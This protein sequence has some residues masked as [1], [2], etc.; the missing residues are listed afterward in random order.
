MTEQTPAQE[1]MAIAR[2]ARAAKLAGAPEGLAT[3]ASVITPVQPV[4]ANDEDLAVRAATQAVA[5][6]VAAL[7]VP[8]ANIPP[9]Q[10]KTN[11]ERVAEA[12]AAEADLRVRAARQRAANGLADPVEQVRVR[13]TKQGDGKISMGKHVPGIGEAY[14]EWKEEFSLPEPIARGLEERY[15]VEIL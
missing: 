1:R 7:P 3:T 10:L 4:A 12:Q 2:A 8:D 13:V 15:F 9:E 11:N 14:Y 6:E 5:R